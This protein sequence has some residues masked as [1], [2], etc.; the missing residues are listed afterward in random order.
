[1]ADDRC[2]GQDRRF[3][4]P[5]DVCETTCPCCGHG[6]EFWKDEPKRTCPR[7]GSEVRHPKLDL[8]CAQW[9]SKAAECLGQAGDASP[10]RERLIGAM[11]A[12]F[13][14]D[15]ARIKHALMVLNHAE[16][17]NEAEKA[18][19]LVVTA[20][21]V[22]H[23][24]GIQEAERR[25]G[26]A[27]G[28]YQEIEG[29]PMARRIMEALKIDEPA[30]HHVCRIIANHHSAKDIDTPEFRVIWDADWLV[31]LPE[32]YP[33]LDPAGL[34]QKIETIFKTAA[35]KKRAL[36]GTMSDER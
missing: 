19:P 11:K 22:L 15:R 5:E 30:I 21:A 8:G 26:S 34:R 36:E 6:L 14:A 12:V 17:I 4:K 20:A 35:G 13:G 2:P 7:C 1:M 31:N 23:D 16:R 3:W 29:P 9:C 18:D 33:G 28:R 24:I 32:V 10:I 27:A 25:Y